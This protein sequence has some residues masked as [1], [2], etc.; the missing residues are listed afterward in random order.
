MSS[1]QTEPRHL[2]AK[3]ASLE[4]QL[5]LAT[6]NIYLVNV[7]V[8]VE[9]PLHRFFLSHLRPLDQCFIYI[10]Q[11]SLHFINCLLRLSLQLIEPTLVGK[12]LSLLVRKQCLL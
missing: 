3:L 12:V 9:V 4:V 2:E 5:A 1:S 6:L 10:A 7:I 8:V 11:P